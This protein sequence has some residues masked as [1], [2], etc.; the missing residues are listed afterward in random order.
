MGSRLIGWWGSER[1]DSG[2]RWEGNG[3][4]SWDLGLLMMLGQFLQSLNGWLKLA[5]KL[6]IAKGHPS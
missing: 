4:G 2:R 6:A 3:R 5:E 1:R